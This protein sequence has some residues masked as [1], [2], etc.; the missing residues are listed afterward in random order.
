MQNAQQGLYNV[1][2]LSLER[3]SVMISI[4]IAN[5][6]KK[7]RDHSSFTFKQHFYMY[8]VNSSAVCGISTEMNLKNDV[9]SLNS[10]VKDA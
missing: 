1:G 2:P 6:V 4:V 8:C 10:D 5:V 9:K 3:F 7:I